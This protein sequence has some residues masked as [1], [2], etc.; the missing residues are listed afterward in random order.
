[1]SDHSLAAHI[2]IVLVEDD[3]GV[4]AAFEQAVSQAPD[5]T[6]AWVA[7]TRALAGPPADVLVADLGLPDG[8][9]I[10]VIRAA[11]ACWPD[12]AIMV[13]TTFGDELSVI[14]SIEAGAN[15]YLLKDS[16]AETM[17]RDIRILHAGGS[18]ISPRIA[19]QMLLR[20]RQDGAAAA[21]PVAPAGLAAG[22]TR[23]RAPD[24]AA[25]PVTLSSRE[26]EVLELITKGFTYDEIA[27]LMQVSRHTVM[28]FV[29]R[30][31]TKLQVKSKVEA[32]YEARLHGLLAP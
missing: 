4:S 3:A 17:L 12:C 13:N 24:G 11:R 27:R 29:R 7:G 9:G 26:Q 6:L 21:P 18:P 10:D 19:C 14:G 28:T 1:M 30:I 23:T 31:Y 5:M 20:F 8:S 22:P 15:G 16:T 32:I 2:H 25:V